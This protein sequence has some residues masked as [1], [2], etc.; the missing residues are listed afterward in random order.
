VGVSFLDH[1]AVDDVQIVA[2][3]VLEV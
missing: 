2:Q 3:S 1:F